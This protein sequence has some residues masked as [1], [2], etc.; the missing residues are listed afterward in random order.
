MCHAAETAAA[1]RFR[2]RNQQGVRGIFNGHPNTVVLD[3]RTFIG[4][5]KTVVAGYAIRIS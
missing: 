3:R 2:R 5:Y 4:L 1:E